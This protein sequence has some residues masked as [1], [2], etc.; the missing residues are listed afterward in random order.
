MHN[1]KK[2]SFEEPSAWE[3]I[4]MPTHEAAKIHLGLEY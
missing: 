1:M 2:K 4:G 3:T